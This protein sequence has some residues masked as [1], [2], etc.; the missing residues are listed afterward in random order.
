M[1][2][3]LTR[4]PIQLP[5]LLAVVAGPD[6]GGVASFLGVVRDHQD[7][8]R[9]I[10]LEY[11]AYEPMAEAEAGRIVAEAEGRWPVRVGLLHR[12]G[13]LAIGDTAV[14]ITAA[15]GHRA[16]AFEACR[17]VIE[18]VKRRVPIWKKEFYADGTVGWVGAGELGRSDGPRDGP[19][20]G[21][22]RVGSP[23][24]A[25]PEGRPGTAPGTR[26]TVERSERPASGPVDRFSRPL[27]SLRI[28]VT[29][30]CNMRCRYCMPEE[31][32][33]W[34]PRASILS[35]EELDRVAG[36]FAGLGVEKLRLTGGEPLLRHDLPALVRLL[37][38]RAGIQDLAL[39]TNGILLGGHAAALR[40]AGLNRLT[41]SLD[42]LRPERMQQFA[43]SARHHEVLEG[44]REAARAGFR[45]IKLNSVI[46]RGYNDDELDALI[47]FGRSE[48]LEVR[49]IEYMDVG[50]ANQ[51]S[52]EEVVSRREILD[53]LA[54]R[55][56]PIEPLAENTASWAPADRFRL[57]DGTVFGIIA[58]TTEPFCRTCDRG[59]LTADGHF[60]LCLYAESGLDLRGPLRDGASDAEI[61]ALI[62]AQWIARTDRG[63]EERAAAPERGA[64]YQ[65]E[66]LRSDPRKE[67]HTRGG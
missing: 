67:M 58:S 55:H 26:A 44:L 38:A 12:L 10:R 62:R 66:T 2:S 31:E 54:R 1:T 37:A 42:T 40:A 16:E 53:R 65:L 30:R 20:E 34:L 13:E 49:F 61:T 59:R 25:D 56:G 14:A 57:S 21:P 5:A 19:S 46:I 4:D 17:Y 29:D 6:R 41:V 33:V 22:A 64:L 8:R 52:A 36:I 7:G 28:S 47:E 18:E 45:G 15:G 43:R 35:F 60:L 51:W 24:T 32:Y 9:V 63:A 23:P 50:G 27:R 39:T 48:G 3:F 11:S